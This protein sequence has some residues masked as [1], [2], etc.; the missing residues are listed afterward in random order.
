MALPRTLRRIT[1]TQLYPDAIRINFQFVA[2]PRGGE[3]EPEEPGTFLNRFQNA[4]R[5]SLGPRNRRS[6]V[7][8]PIDI[9]QASEE[10]SATITRPPGASVINAHVCINP[11]R[12]MNAAGGTEIPLDGSNNWMRP[13]QVRTDNRRVWH[14]ADTLIEETSIAL[15]ER[16]NRFP[17]CEAQGYRFRLAKTFVAQAEVAVD[18]GSNNPQRQTR[19]YRSALNALCGDNVRRTYNLV[20]RRL[21]NSVQIEG[22]VW[23]DLRLKVY[24]KTN[25]R[26]RFELQYRRKALNDIGSGREINIGSRSFSDFFVQLAEDAVPTL[27]ELHRSRSRQRIVRPTGPSA[28]RLIEASYAN[29]RDPRVASQC[30]ITLCETGRIHSSINRQ[31]VYRLRDD[32]I[33]EPTRRRGF[34]IVTPQYRS[35][36]R[37][38]KRTP[39]FSRRG[40]E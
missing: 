30:L 20:D 25:R 23:P 24:S 31:Y 19:S 33:L 40:A 32:G 10:Y 4:A 8:M 35:A 1:A 9:V 13:S 21:R 27:H 22:Y 15:E 34:Y 7:R 14:L 17:V 12:A 16:L 36:L 6:P 39:N 2:E 18:M 38:L 29:T 3:R 26:V 28:S 11:L 5:N 37:A